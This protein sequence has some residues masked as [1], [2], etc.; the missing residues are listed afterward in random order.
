MLRLRCTAVL[1]GTAMRTLA[2]QSSSSSDTP[3]APFGS[4]S[5]PPPRRRSDDTSTSTQLPHHTP[6]QASTAA[7]RVYGKE[8]FNFVEHLRTSGPGAALGRVR[9]TLSLYIAAGT[10]VLVYMLYYLTTY[11]YVLTNDPA[12]YRNTLFQRF[13]CDFA[14]L[15][16]KYTKVR[17]AVEVTRSGAASTSDNVAAASSR[18][19]DEEGNA[20]VDTRAA[21]PSPAVVERKLHVN[22]LLHRVFLYLQK[23]HSLVLVDAQAELQPQRFMN[24]AH[25]V[26]SDVRAPV[27]FLRE[28]QLLPDGAAN[29]GGATGAGAAPRSGSSW[30]WPWS[31]SKKTST[32][33]SVD[34]KGSS[35]SSNG[36]ATAQGPVQVFVES[37]VRLRDAMN[38]YQKGHLFTYEQTLSHV[39]QTKL[40]D[41]F[42]RYTLE[43]G[44]AENKGL[45]RVFAEEMMRNGLISGTGVTLSMLVPD[46]QQFA[47]EVFNDVKEKFGDDVI[48]YSYCVK[49]R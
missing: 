41:R 16:N 22:A 5:A 11:T 45:R 6:V 8:G 26:G 42:F 1:C 40:V 31:R 27:A 21:R 35:A 20:S 49:L 36:A 18:S 33:L 23:S 7:R 44:M 32:A 39:V 17:H 25:S 34:A 19:A 24:R 9:W 47:D 2:S 28:D 30:M 12:P 3:S 14:I 48:I 13:P 38:G 15:E 43:R 10:V 29:S 4:S 37:E 46:A